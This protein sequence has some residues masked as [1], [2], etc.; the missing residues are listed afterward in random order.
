ME[1]A[2]EKR[3]LEINE[4]PRICCID[5]DEEVV[6]YLCDS[7]FNL[8]SGTL[9][10]KVKVPNKK[11]HENHQLLL[12]YDFPEN[13]HEY[14]IFLIDLNNSKTIDYNS[15]DHIR[16]NHTGK[17]AISLLSSYP[18]TIF[19][20]RPLSSVILEKKLKQIGSRT[21][22]IITFTTESYE[23]EYET[24]LITE[25]SVSRHGYEKHHIYSYIGNV[26]LSE[27]KYGKEMIVEDV[28]Q[29]LKNMLE[30]SLN[31]SIYNQTFHHPT[32]WSNES[33]IPSIKYKPLIRNSN[34][35]IVSFIE[36]R[37]NAI[38]F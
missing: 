25:D 16:E 34:N 22:M 31:D 13:I 38:L 32:T 7:G 2:K 33:Q 30:K 18:E 9:G 8:Y 27:S 12:N 35:D 4:R 17:K 1:E 14:D 20:P 29:D 10:D 28:R 24:V 5:I 15:K 37:D 36:T 6:K 26:P 19:D 11:R 3:K 23:I 21:H